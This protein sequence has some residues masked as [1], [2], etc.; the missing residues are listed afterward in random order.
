MLNSSAVGSFKAGRAELYDQET[1][2]GTVA[3]VRATWS[4]ITLNSHH[5]EQAFS[6]GGG[7]T[8]KT[9]F[10]ATLTRKSD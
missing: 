9:N 2:H 8:W 5:F 3:L 7:K 1:F 10:V 4:D 6:T